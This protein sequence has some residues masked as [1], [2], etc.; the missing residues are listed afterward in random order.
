MD[1]T[2]GRAVAQPLGRRERV[3]LIF[4]TRGRPTR[5]LPTLGGWLARWSGLTDL[6]VVIGLD[7]DDETAP[8]VRAR[9]DDLRRIAE[10]ARGAAGADGSLRFAMTY[11]RPS[12][13]VQAVN[14]CADAG[15]PRD[16]AFD[17][18]VVASDDMVCRL[19]GWDARIVE[20]AAADSSGFGLARDC[21]LHYFDGHRADLVTLPVLG[22]MFFRR[23]GGVYHHEYA[24]EWCDNEMTEIARATG[25][26]IDRT[27]IT[28]AEHQHPAN[29]RPE[30]DDATYQRARSR[31]ECDRRLYEM[32][33][34]DQGFEWPQRPTLSVLVV[35]T[36]RRAGR[37]GLLVD[38]LCSP[39][40]SLPGRLGV[41]D[42]EL[43]VTVG[44]AHADG[45]RPVGDRRQALLEFARG[46]WVVFVDDDDFLHPMAITQWLRAIGRANDRVAA[47]EQ[48][49]LYRRRSAMDRWL[50]ARWAVYEQ[51]AGAERADP[52]GFGRGGTRPV[53]HITPLRRDLIDE[54]MGFCRSLAEGED[55]DF[56]Q[57]VAVCLR[58]RMA[59]PDGRGA[60]VPCDLP[61]VYAYEFRP[62]GTMTQRGWGPDA[63]RVM[64]A[65]AS[66]VINEAE[67]GG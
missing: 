41:R 65:W 50:D 37:L 18:L 45:G 16:H 63:T 55:D 12:T 10:R 26:L 13:K 14:R 24:S 6:E 60:G 40:R 33:R 20:D 57:R 21:L 25:R 1:E 22:A 48:R 46:R 30:L 36:P 2:L 67:K 23:L 54:A 56:A 64:P 29:G 7:E 39:L 42:V 43:R 5:A 19:R 62:D 4:P 3:R 59:G 28:I 9:L 31:A 32:R 8:H 47:I 49:V 53:N 35:S 11:G 27:E 15:W 51:A 61:W 58:N 38:E 44:D 52:D 17:W 66:A 34:P